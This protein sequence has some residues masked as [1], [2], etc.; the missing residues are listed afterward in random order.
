MF[1]LIE[2]NLTIINSD[3]IYKAVSGAESRDH[4]KIFVTGVTPIHFYVFIKYSGLRIF[5]VS[6]NLYVIPLIC[7]MYSF[8]MP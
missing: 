7:H 8:L 3:L 1:M 2:N 4:S 5:S 6:K